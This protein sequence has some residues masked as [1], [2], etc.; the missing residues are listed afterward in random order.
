MSQGIFALLAAA[1]L[2]QMSYF[3][4]V[5]AR[6]A[7]ASASVAPAVALRGCGCVAVP[8]AV[9]AP[10]LPTS[11]LPA[12][13]RGRRAGMQRRRLRLGA[14]SD[15]DLGL[16]VAHQRQDG[17]HVGLPTDVDGSDDR[18]VARGQSLEKLGGDRALRN[19]PSSDVVG[20]LAPLGQLGRV[21]HAVVPVLHAT[22]PEVA[23]DAA[24]IVGA[25]RT[26]ARLQ[27][28]VGL[29]CGSRGADEWHKA[30]VHVHHDRQEGHL[31]GCLALCGRVRCQLVSVCLLQCDLEKE[32]PGFPV[33]A[34]A[35]DQFHEL[36]H[37][38]VACG[39]V[40]DH[41]G[42]RPRIAHQSLGGARTCTRT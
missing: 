28:V 20:E 6:P 36:G 19:G 37:S 34:W 40:V 24:K 33:C 35:I 10:A 29:T 11:E 15:A 42:L 16:E 27:P 22:C 1:I 31:S 8:A 41:L 32:V 4:A 2:D 38:G 3:A 9:T 26:E 18:L 14:S 12:E 25:L 5:V 21:G 7:F 30:K 23:K 13:L 39:G 17:V